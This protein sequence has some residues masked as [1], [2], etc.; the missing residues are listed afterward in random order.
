MFVVW[1]VEG[2][3]YSLGQLVGTEQ[4][5]GFYHPPF[6]VNPFGL[7]G[8][9]PRALLGQKA[10]DDAYSM[11]A[12]FDLLVVRAYPGVHL[13]L[14][15][16]QLALS[17]INTQTFLPTAASFSEHHDTKRV[18]MG[19]TGRPSTSLSHIFSSSGT[20]SP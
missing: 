10:A 9:Q 3:A 17:Q 16:C 20:K 5:I 7:Y 1:T 19:L 13:P 15:M 18:V 12:V 2:H 8:V 6:A 14:W 4:T 11:S